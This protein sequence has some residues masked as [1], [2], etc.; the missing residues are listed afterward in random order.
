MEIRSFATG[1]EKRGDGCTKPRADK[2]RRR[3]PKLIG[4][5]R[6]EEEQTLGQATQKMGPSAALIKGKGRSG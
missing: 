4:T 1:R 2:K 3:N 5:S 6:A